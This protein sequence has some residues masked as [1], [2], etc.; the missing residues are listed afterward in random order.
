MKRL[1]T[2]LFALSFQ[3]ASAQKGFFTKVES[4]DNPSARSVTHLTRHSVFNIQT[5][6]L[7]AYLAGAPLEFGK[8]NAVGRTL[9]IPLPDGNVVLFDIFESPI[10]A[11]AIAAKHPEIKTYAGK[12]ITNKAYSVRINFTQA[13]FSAIILGAGSDAVYFEKIDLNAADSIYRSYFSRDAISPKDATEKTSNNHCGTIDSESRVKQLNTNGQNKRTAATASTGAT[14]RTFRLAMAADAEFT[15]NKGGTAALAYAALTNYVN[16]MNAVYRKELSVSFELVS[17]ETIV[18]TDAASDPYTNDNQSTMLDEN[19]EHLD[20]VMTAGYDIGHVLGYAGSS[21]GGIAARGSVCDPSSKGQGVSG[22]GDGSYPD[23]FDQQLIQHEVGH[24]FDMGHSYNSNVPVCTTRAHDTSV[25]PGSGTTI[26]SYGYTCSNTDPGLGMLGNDDYEGTYQPILNFH[27]A[28]YDQAN[29]FIETLSC[30][31]TSA[32]NNAVP[33]INAMATSWTIPKST[34]FV[35]TGS[36]TDADAGDVLSFSW[37]GTNISDESNK[38]LLTAATISDPSRP[39]FFRSYAPV[40][41]STGP[42]AGTRYYPR[43]EAIL[44]GSNYAIGDKLPSIGIAT[45]HKLTVRDNDSGVSSAEVTVNVDDSGPFLITNDTPG[46]LL[47]PT[48]TY[49]LGG[50]MTVMWSVNGTAGAPVNCKRVDIFLSTDGGLTFPTT[51]LTDW[52][53]AGT[54]AVV[55]PLV[56]TFKARIKIAPSTSTLAGHVPNVFFDISNVNFIIGSPMP[57][58]LVSFE[59]K[60]DS[61]N[62]AMLTWQTSEERNNAGFDIEMSLDARTF[63]KVG[64]VDGNGNTTAAKHYQYP[65]KDLSGGKYYFR[66]KQLDYDGKFEYSQIRAIELKSARD[67]LAVYPNPTGGKLKIHPSLHKG[68]A[69]SVQIVN[70]SGRTVVSL[71]TSD[72]YSKDYELDASDLPSGIYSIILKGVNFTESLRFVKQ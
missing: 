33:V 46:S 21:G 43:L 18:Y 59:A 15:A 36:A 25:E 17:D 9:E 11:P 51:L 55:L 24:Q 54:A 49:P 64:F 10:L 8:K 69:F 7:K 53:N 35:L 65:V 6:N 27:A 5:K 37:E 23:V 32:T 67:F 45:T 2:V 71:P 70:Q 44:D 19:Q 41:A 20:N 58:T 28:S 16:N 39:P 40:S 29:A 3:F 52:P 12:G 60:P 57:V 50:A 30:F 14:L 31:T 66:L 62:S 34:P 1:L 42:D 68:Q 47:G 38:A 48:G 72:I 26:M 22:V 4:S 56:D 63:S 61:E 13:G